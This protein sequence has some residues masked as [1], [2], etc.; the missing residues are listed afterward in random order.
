MT[1]ITTKNTNGTIC[2][3]TKESLPSSASGEGDE[4]AVIADKKYNE[5]TARK[6][7]EAKQ[8]NEGLSDVING[9][10][11]DGDAVKHRLKA[12]YKL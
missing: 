5:T 2:P 4:K 10:T 3:H 8:I 1:S 9:R 6:L 11:V 12:R 7:Y